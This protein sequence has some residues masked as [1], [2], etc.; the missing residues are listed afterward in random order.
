MVSNI[1]NTNM[2]AAELFTECLAQ[3][4]TVVKQVM[5]SHYANATPDSDSDVRDVTNH[6]LNVLAVISSNSF[7]SELDLDNEAEIEAI[8]KSA[9]DLSVQWQLAADAAEAALNEMDLDD[10]IS[11]NGEPI[12]IENLL[13]QLAGELLIHSWDLGEAIG[14]PV[15]FNQEVA[16]AVMETTVVPNSIAIPNH[17]LFAE[18]IDPPANADLQARLLALF[19][20]SHAWR[21]TS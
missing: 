9:F 1:N 12:V 15:R 6:M 21:A 10:T 5:P 7:E 17:N 13:V 20:R 19:G 18:P 11:Y 3:A 2:D 4:T 14:M 8:D 16:E